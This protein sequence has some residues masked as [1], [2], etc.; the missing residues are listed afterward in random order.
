MLMA[1]PL[2]AQSSGPLPGEDRTYGSV[3]PAP[4]PERRYAPPPFPKF[5]PTPPKA[6]HIR[7]APKAKVAAKSAPVLKSE[8]AALRDEKR[9]KVRKVA[10]KE[11][12]LSNREIKDQRWCGTLT[13]KQLSRNAKCRRV[14]DKQE[15]A[16]RVAKPTPVVLTK[17]DRKDEIR[18]G[19]L[20][21]NQVLRDA[22]CRKVAERHL[23]GKP[24]AANTK[25]STSRTK[26]KASA[27]SR[28]AKKRSRR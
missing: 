1:T 26:A 6:R 25:A 16:K 21:L 18:C 8:R 11:Q 5:S 13:K 9:A 20:S 12:R 23:S 3:P 2:M 24:A 14:L 4:P 28:P 7:V 19:R 10:S 22:R 15:A 17:A 27:K